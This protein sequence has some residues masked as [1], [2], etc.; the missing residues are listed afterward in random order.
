MQEHPQ[1][2]STIRP[3]SAPQERCIANG[4][5]KV[6]LGPLLFSLN[7]RLRAW[8]WPPMYGTKQPK[9]AARGMV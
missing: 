4:G 8:E 7:L 9:G 2:V 1:K 6:R 5:T 3:A